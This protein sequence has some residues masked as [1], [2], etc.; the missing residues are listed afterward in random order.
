MLEIFGIEAREVDRGVDGKGEPGQAR[1][2]R[3]GPRGQRW[4]VGMLFFM[5]RL[6]QEAM[7]A[8]PH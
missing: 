3:G 5:Q 4:N 8:F 6:Q 2:P 7:Q 1:V